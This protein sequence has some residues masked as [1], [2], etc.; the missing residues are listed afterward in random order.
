MS[1]NDKQRRTLLKGAAALGVASSIPV[2]ANA[3]IE[4]TV[5]ANPASNDIFSSLLEQSFRL[6]RLDV[7]GAIPVSAVLTEVKDLEFHCSNHQR[8]AQLRNC[9]QVLRFTVSDA[10]SFDSALYA[11]K[12]PEI[13]EIALM[14]SATPDANGHWALEAILN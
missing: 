10:Q 3:V 11:L 5:S 9:A 6:S 2:S 7:E 4:A 1:N 8:P 14:M 13:G 12:H